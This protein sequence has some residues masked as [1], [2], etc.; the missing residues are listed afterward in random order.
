MTKMRKKKVTGRLTAAFIITL[1][2]CAVAFAALSGS[3]L[4]DRLF[5]ESQGAASTAP[6]PSLALPSPTQSPQATAAQTVMVT[7][8]IVFP[9]VSYYAIQTGAFSSDASAKE[10][11]EAIKSVGGAGYVLH[12]TKYRVLASMYFDAES[13]RAVKESLAKNDVDCYIYSGS[14]P[15]LELSVT[16]PGECINALDNAYGLLFEALEQ[17]TAL[18][19]DVDSQQKTVSEAIDALS[20]QK[21]NLDEACMGL[22]SCEQVFSQSDILDGFLSVNESAADAARKICEN[23]AS[24]AMALSSAMRYNVIDTIMRYSEFIDMLSDKSDAL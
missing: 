9:A 7:R 5:G 6:A 20:V 13:A 10:A 23:T 22:S 1:A 14:L 15:K 21:N 19:D 3:S 2:L 17:M 11:S 12:D 4:A 18:A 8:D 24:D 16:A